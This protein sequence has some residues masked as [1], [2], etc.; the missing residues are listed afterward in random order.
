MP[1]PPPINLAAPPPTPQTNSLLKRSTTNTQIYDP[2]LPNTTMSLSYIPTSL[3]PHLH[4]LLGPECASNILSADH[5]TQTTPECQILL[6]SKVTGLLILLLGSTLKIP[7]L[8]P[9]LTSFSTRGISIPPL[10]LETIGFTIGI[11]YNIRAA[12]PFTTWGEAP[13]LLGANLLIF[14]VHFLSKRPRSSGVVQFGIAT[15]IYTVFFRTLFNTQIV[16]PPILQT[17]LSATVPI[18]TSSAVLQILTNYRLKHIGAISPA[19]LTM[20]LA[21]GIGRLVTT[22]VEIEDGVM[23]FA[24]ALGCALGVVQFLQMVVYRDGTRRFLEGSKGPVGAGGG[25]KVGKSKR[26]E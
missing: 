13:F 18:F 3:H 26:A 12:N 16:T 5:L 24:S 23:R 20:G 17:L 10:L 15:A 11:A 8:L 22:F 25:K 2:L 4:T 19:T 21:C 7:S 9:I 6:F 1:P 14:A